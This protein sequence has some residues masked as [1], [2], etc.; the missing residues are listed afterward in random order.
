MIALAL[1]L[2]SFGRDVMW[3]WARRV[4]KVSLAT[5]RPAVDVD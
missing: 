1:L 2:E 5:Q 4:P 3:L